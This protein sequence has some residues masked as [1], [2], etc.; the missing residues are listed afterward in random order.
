LIWCA[1]PAAC[2]VSPPT[3]GRRAGRWWLIGL[4]VYV[5]SPIDPIPDFILGIGHVDELIVVPLVLRR[6]KRMIPPDVWAEH[7]PPRL[8]RVEATN[9]AAAS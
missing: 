3:D 4:A 2:A 7:F 9:D 6:I 1:C 5:A 8:G